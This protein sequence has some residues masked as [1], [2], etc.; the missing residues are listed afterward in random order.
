M[1]RDPA[2]PN[3]AES[4]NLLHMGYQI[5]GFGT[6]AAQTANASTTNYYRSTVETEADIVICRIGSDFFMYY[7][8]VSK[9]GLWTLAST[10]SRP[11][12]PQTLQVG[13]STDSMGAQPYLRAEF[14]YVRFALPTVQADCTANIPP[15]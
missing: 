12:L 7:T 14:D 8:T 13:V 3:V 6:R 15:N 1:V 5:S 11:D 10:F 4:W 9:G 2:S